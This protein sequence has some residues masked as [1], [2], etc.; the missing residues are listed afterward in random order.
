MAA[1]QVRDGPWWASLFFAYLAVGIITLGIFAPLYYEMA[2]GRLSSDIPAHA[3]ILQT[4]LRTGHWPP[5]PGLH[6]VALALLGFSTSP[7]WKSLI[8]VLS[9]MTLAALLAKHLL[10]A[11][12]LVS[13]QPSPLSRNQKVN[14]TSVAH[15]GAMGLRLVGL[16]MCLCVAGP[17]WS[18]EIGWGNFYIGKFSPNLWHN[19]TLLLSW[20]L[21]ILHFA[22]VIRYL[23]RPSAGRLYQ[24]VLYEA[25]ATIIKPNY[26]V[27][28]CGAL[29]LTLL[30]SEFRSR[31]WVKAVVFQLVI[32]VMVLIPQWIA[33]RSGEN[34]TISIAPF[35][36][37]SQRSTCVPLTFLASVGFPLAVAVALGRTI[38][39]DRA[40][41]LAAALFVVAAGQAYLFVEGAT[42]RGMLDGNWFWGGHA[43]LFLL[44]FVSLAALCRTTFVER[45]GSP[46]VHAC[47]GVFGLHVASGIAWLGKYFLGYGYF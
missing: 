20:P 41:Q 25:F 31:A 45:R 30:F 18:P 46:G 26:T 5:H 3:E 22:G 24:I 40:F 19:P 35:A 37:V 34:A 43:T 23:D 14:T 11:A 33:F 10:V 28:L 38:I 29:P 42:G 47:W 8:I 1:G 6:L 13:W 32:A 44:F 7:T 17:V 9:G 12:Y 21:I 39:L 2:R 4:A 16:T 27:A 15:N 36:I